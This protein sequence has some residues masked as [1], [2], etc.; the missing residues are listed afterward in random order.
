MPAA[1]AIVYALAAREPQRV[2]ESLALALCT[3][4]IAQ[5]PLA[6]LG[7]AFSGVL[8]IEGSAVRRVVVYLGVV[9]F[10]AA[11]GWLG[12]RTSASFLAPALGLAVATQVLSL[13]F[14]GNDVSR[15]RKRISAAAN[16]AV[17]LIVLAFWAVFVA[18][19]AGGLVQRYAAAT[20]AGFRIELRLGHL[21]WVV[22]AYF[23]LRA[24]SA[25]YVHTAAFAR[26]GKGYFERPW[27]EWLVQHLGRSESKD[28][29]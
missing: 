5:L 14:L 29:D 20:L 3:L 25:A 11:V 21:A 12:I 19:V 27:I 17:N 4:F 7:G 18:L 13:L 26:R 23:A 1:T 8:Y 16:D 22:A 28:D 15:A 24:V 9:G 6:V 10:V 2:P